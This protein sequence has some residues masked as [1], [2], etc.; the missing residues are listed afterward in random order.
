MKPVDAILVYKPLGADSGGE[1]RLCR[2]SDPGAIRAV[3]R[4]ALAE[5]RETADSWRGIDSDV[6]AMRDAEATKLERVLDM[7]LP[8]DEPSTSPLRLVPP[9]GAR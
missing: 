4:A 1:F 6:A 2:S 5:A 7:I 3:G 9:K 8:P